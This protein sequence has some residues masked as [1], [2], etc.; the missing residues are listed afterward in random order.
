MAFQYLKGCCNKG[1]G[2]LVSSVCCD[3]TRENGFK[4][5]EERFTLDIWKK[6]FTVRVVRH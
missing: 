1:G 6:F 4:L 3:R 2:R 5:E